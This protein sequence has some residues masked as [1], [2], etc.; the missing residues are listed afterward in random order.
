[1]YKY[2]IWAANNKGADQTTRMRR[3]IPTFA[4]DRPSD[5][6]KKTISTIL[7]LDPDWRLFLARLSD[8]CIVK[9]YIFCHFTLI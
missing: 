1:M 7:V 3:L 8:N 4:F 2:T 9:K 6:T 5:Q